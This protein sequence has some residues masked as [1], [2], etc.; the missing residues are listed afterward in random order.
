MTHAESCHLSA[1]VFC[2][3][4]SLKQ[5]AEDLGVR[6]VLEG[7]IRRAGGTIRVNAQL[8]DALSGN[9]VWA[10]RFDGDDADIFALQDKIND[11]IVAA[12]S[13]NVSYQLRDAQAIF[14]AARKAA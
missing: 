6:Y 1:F 14:A 13:E 10:E 3:P 4:G 7:S 8:I 9:H 2:F 5:V 12:L 11:K